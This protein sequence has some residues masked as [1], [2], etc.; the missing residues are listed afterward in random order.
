MLLEPQRN[1]DRKIVFLEDNLRDRLEPS[2]PAS[3]F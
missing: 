2:K 1:L 3:L